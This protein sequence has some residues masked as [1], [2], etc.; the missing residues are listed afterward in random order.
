MIPPDLP[1]NHVDFITEV[2]EV[3]TRYGM[4][5]FTLEYRQ[6]REDEYKLPNCM[7]GDIK[8]HFTTKDGRGRPEH[9]IVVEFTGKLLL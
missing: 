3:A 8:A 7:T 9:R 2:S 5:R 6:N 1:Q 4:E